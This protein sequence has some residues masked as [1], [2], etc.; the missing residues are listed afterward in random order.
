ME[1][2]QT[3]YDQDRGGFNLQ[4]F[5]DSAGV[6]K[7]IFFFINSFAV[8]QTGDVSIKTFAVDGLGD[9]KVVKFVFL[10]RHLVR[11]GNI[12]VVLRYQA[13][14]VVSEMFQK[15]LQEKGLSRSASPGNANN[16]WGP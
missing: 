16:K 9:V 4:H 2:K 1:D 3:L 5:R 6:I 14:L 7:S 11:H 12:V 8:D 13:N 15:T 10:R